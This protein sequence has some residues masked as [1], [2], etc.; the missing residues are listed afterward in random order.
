MPPYKTEYNQI[1][2]WELEKGKKN[3]KKIVDSHHGVT[4]KPWEYGNMA[5]P[6]P[7]I[8]SK[9]FEKTVLWDNYDKKNSSNQSNELAASDDPIL[10]NLRMQL[11][12]RGGVGIFGLAKKFHIMDDDGR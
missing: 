2:I 6:P 10:D 8:S 12:K 5:L 7:T 1:N 11:R 9:R 3:R 4:I